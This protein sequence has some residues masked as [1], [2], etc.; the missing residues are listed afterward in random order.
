MVTFVLWNSRAEST[1][2]R[3]PKVQQLHQGDVSVRR[4]W[5]LPGWSQLFTARPKK[6][7]GSNYRHVGYAVPKSGELVNRFVGKSIYPCLAAA[8]SNFLFRARCVATSAVAQDMDNV[9]LSPGQVHR[10]PR[11]CCHPQMP[12][13][14]NL[15]G[16]LH[17]ILSFIYW[18][19][20]RSYG[21]ILTLSFKRVLFFSGTKNPRQCPN[22]GFFHKP[23]GKWPQTAQTEISLSDTHPPRSA[24]T[25]VNTEVLAMT[26]PCNPFVGA[27]NSHGAEPSSLGSVQQSSDLSMHQG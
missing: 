26:P 17:T 7:L 1:T 12:F 22:I 13:G 27:K 15:A 14:S 2:N 18:F 20:S 24:G 8:F 25:S 6:I 5:H 10:N 9:D 23:M 11:V 19:T 3:E 16:E 21:K 4:Q